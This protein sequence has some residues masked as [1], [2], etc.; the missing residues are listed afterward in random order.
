MLPAIWAATAYPQRT[1]H[2]VLLLAALILGALSPRIYSQISV[3]DYFSGEPAGLHAFLYLDDDHQLELYDAMNLPADQWLIPEVET[4]SFGYNTATLWVK[5]PVTNLS[6]QSRRL[7]LEISYPILDEVEAYVI[8]DGYALNQYKMGDTINFDQ[9]PVQ[10]RNFV[11]PFELNAGDSVTLYLKIHTEGTL[12]G[13]VLP[14][15]RS[16]SRPDSTFK[17]ARNCGQ[18][19][20]R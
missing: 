1:R 7:G 12:Q 2:T 9:R 5:L 17:A 4:T 6:S 11:V 8:Q 14:E 15:A 18:S 10:F 16:S 3:T 20:S 13:R 19:S